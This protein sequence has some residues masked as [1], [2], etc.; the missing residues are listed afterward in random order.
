VEEEIV[1]AD[2]PLEGV[3]FAVPDPA[4]TTPP[5]TAQTLVARWVDGYRTS[6][7][8]QDPPGPLMRRVAGQAKNLAKSCDNDA[9]WGAAWRASYAAGQAG[10]ADAV[11]LMASQRRP[12]QETRN[13]FLKMLENDAAAGLLDHYRNDPRS[14]G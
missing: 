8:G 13:P 6:N 7:A 9:D 5:Q 4:P 11:P 12:Q 3:L 10:R 2:E 14:I 1:H